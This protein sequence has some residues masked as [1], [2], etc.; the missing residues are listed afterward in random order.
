M[1]NI[2]MTILAMVRQGAPSFREMARITGLSLSGVRLRILGL[3]DQGFLYKPLKG[4]R[5]SRAL[6]ATENGQALFPEFV[7]AVNEDGALNRYN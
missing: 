4:K 3:M 2:D 7:I 6:K 1:D 5:R